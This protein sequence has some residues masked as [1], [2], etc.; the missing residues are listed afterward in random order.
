M[1]TFNSSISQ[2]STA[3]TWLI[4]GLSVV[5]MGTA[6]VAW[7]KSGGDIMVVV[8]SGMVSLLLFA[9]IGM[10]YLLR[11]TGISVTG[12]AIM[13]ER[14]IKPVTIPFSDIKEIKNVSKE[15]MG[16]VIRTFGNGG[17][18]GYT[19]MYYSKKQG[20]MMWYCTRLGNY[21]IIETRDGKKVVIS[22][23]NP[24]ELVRAVK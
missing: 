2:S 3:I 1:S 13:I 4:G 18:F 21:V 16:R 24:Q 11:T 10:M 12:D 7:Q 23:D 22:P 14:K 8:L 5:I 9:T 19:G 20:S 17:L 6:Y 15:E